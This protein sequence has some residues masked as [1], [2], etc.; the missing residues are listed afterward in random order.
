MITPL[1]AA[2]LRRWAANGRL[3]I[4]RT[5]GTGHRRYSA[6]EVRALAPATMTATPPEPRIIGYARVSGHDQKASGDLDSQVGRL[7]AAGASEV[8]TDVASGLSETRAG[9]TRLMRRAA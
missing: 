5:G 8:I 2:T 1:H 7:R 6:A 4:V 9:L 3:T